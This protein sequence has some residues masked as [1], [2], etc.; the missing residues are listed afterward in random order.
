LFSQ[1]E[2]DIKRNEI[3]SSLEFK[4]T[5][6]HQRLSIEFKPT[7]GA[8]FSALELHALWA[9]RIALQK[10]LFS[11]ASVVDRGDCR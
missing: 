11:P 8:R 4:P 9:V 1:I 5:Q 7:A 3:G 6:L 10:K 2:N